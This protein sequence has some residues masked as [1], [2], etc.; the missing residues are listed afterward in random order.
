MS[1]EREPGGDIVDAYLPDPETS[2][3]STVPDPD[4]TAEDQ[5]EPAYRWGGPEGKN[6]VTNPKGIT[7]IADVDDSD[8]WPTTE[9]RERGWWFRKG[10]AIIRRHRPEPAALEA[11]TRR[12]REVS[13]YDLS[14]IA[15]TPGHEEIQERIEAERKHRDDWAALDEREHQDLIDQ[16]DAQRKHNAGLKEQHRQRENATVAALQRQAE[17]LDPTT[18][19]IRLDKASKYLPWLALVPAALAVAAG[20]VNVG[21]KLAEISPSTT[22][23]GWMVEP[24]FTI[25]VVVI[26]IAQIAGAL[27]RP[28]LSNGIREAVK[29]N[30]YFG[31]ELFLLAVAVFLN[32]GTHALTGHFVAAAVWLTVP[33]GLGLSAY[34]VPKI[35]NDLRQALAEW[36]NENTNEPTVLQ[37]RNTRLDVFPATVPS[38]VND[39]AEQAAGELEQ[40][41]FR[42]LLDAVRNSR[43]DPQRNRPIDPTSGASIARVLKV[44]REVAIELRDRY[45]NAPRNTQG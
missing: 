10:K 39:D 9:Q 16:E 19:L 5:V 43:I 3:E 41:P 27:P 12:A 44:R 1:I 38:Q 18:Q 24:L 15:Q 35:V 33:A 17:I 22:L 20:A 30:R 23:V 42:R 14:L 31:F 25:P 36:T 40:D 37:A 8:I 28:D 6:L 13:A 7:P 11:A 2:E 21:T 32:S 45:K 29:D 26:L 4:T 34:L